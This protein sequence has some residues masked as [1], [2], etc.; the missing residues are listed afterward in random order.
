MP[1]LLKLPAWTGDGNIHVVVETPRGGHSKVKYDAELHVFTLSKPLA[2]GLSYPYDFGFIPSTLAE[3]GDPLDA[4]VFHEAVGTPGL[5]IRCRAIG[6][7]KVS[8]SEGRK[9]MRNDRIIA[10]PE[11][12]HRQAGLTDARTLPKA[13]RSELERFFEASVVLKGKKLDFLGWAG[14]GDAARLIR[15][16]EAKFSG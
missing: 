3:D 16:A 10:V 1:E 8:Q 13:F 6:A 4:L 9:R 15:D 11:D 12:D 14:P 7:V 5:V 2:E